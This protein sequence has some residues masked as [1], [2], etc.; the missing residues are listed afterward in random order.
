MK[1]IFIFHISIIDEMKTVVLK[2]CIMFI[3]SQHYVKIWY[4]G[5]SWKEMD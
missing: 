4:S 3:I 2:N 5:L 1:L